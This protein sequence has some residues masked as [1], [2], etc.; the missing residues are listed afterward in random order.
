MTTLMGATNTLRGSETTEPG[1]GGH[2]VV[3]GSE[4]QSWLVRLAGDRDRVRVRMQLITDTDTDAEGHAAAAGERIVKVV[5][6]DGDDVEGHALALHFP[7]VG[8]AQAFK[9]GLAAG[10]LA[11]TLVLGGAAGAVSMSHSTSAAPPAAAPS[12]HHVTLN[13][14]PGGRRIAD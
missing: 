7:T 8:D 11:A 4:D 3:I 14:Q 12:V 13:L 5:V 1:T 10:A 9:K 6:S 2:D